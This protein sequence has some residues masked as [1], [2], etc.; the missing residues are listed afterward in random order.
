MAKNMERN[1]A[2]KQVYL[3]AEMIYKYLLGDEDMETLV[4]CKPGKLDMITT[5]QSL[6]EAIGSV[7]DKEHINY[8]KL[9]K[10]LENVDVL[11]FRHALKKKRTVLREERVREI[12]EKSKDRTDL[13]DLYREVKNAREKD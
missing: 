9:V 7:K 4:F 8:S 3:R 2:R 10:F 12:K 11:S 1:H 6:Y 13:N 5:D